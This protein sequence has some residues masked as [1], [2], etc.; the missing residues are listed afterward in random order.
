MPCP[1]LRAGDSA[2][3]VPDPLLCSASYAGADVA[4]LVCAV[5]QGVIV[6]LDASSSLA[7]HVM[8]VPAGT[9]SMPTGICIDGAREQV[10]LLD[11]AQPSL[12]RIALADLRAGNAQFTWTALPSAWSAVRGIAFDS[13]RDRVVG[14]DPTTGDLLQHTAS[15]PSLVAGSLRPLA[16]VFSFGFAPA[17]NPS[18][19]SVDVDLFITSGDERMLT[20][21]WTWNAATTDDELATLRATVLTSTWVPPCPDPAAITYDALND[22]LVVADSEVDEMTIYAGANVFE[23]SRTGVVAR[24]STTVTY[25]PE[26]SGMTLDPVT[27][28]FYFCDDDRDKIYVVA[29]G[30]DGLL[31]T[32]D[33]SIRSFSVRNFCADAESLAFDSATGTLWIAGGIANLLHKLRPGANGIFDGTPPNGDDVLASFDVAGFGVTDLGGVALRPADGGLYV[34]G[35]P[36]TRLLHLN[37]QGQLVRVITLPATSM[38]RPAGLVFAPSTVGAGDSLFLVDR[39]H[40]NDLEPFENDGKLRQ[41]T[42]P[43]PVV[44]NQPPVVS[45]GP[46]VATS[47]NSAAHLAGLVSDDGLPFGLLTVEW[48]PMAGPGTAT[49][50][51][52]TQPV[53]DAS[54]SAA[55]SYTLELSAYDGELVRVDTVVVT[56]TQPNLPPV[57]DAGPDVAT[58]GTSAAH[59]AGNVSDDGLQGPLAI[60]WTQL[61]GPG[62]ASFTAPNQAV[63]D[64]SFSAVGSYTIQLSAF[65]GELTSTD[66][67]VVAVAQPNLAPVVNAGPDVTTVIPSMAHLVGT[68]SDDGLQR[69]LTI[70]W[71][72]LSGP[73][74]ASFTAPAQPVTDVSF[75]LAGSYTLELSAFDGGLTSTDTVVVTAQPA[76]S[77]TFNRAIS[78]GNDDAEERPT[79]IDRGSQTLEMVLDG[80]VSQVV[81]LRFTSVAIPKGAVITSAYLQFTTERVTSVA[82]Q[83]SIVGQASDNAAPFQ[84]ALLNISSRPD[85]TA[86]VAWA[87]APWTV[88]GQAGLDQRT[89][90]LASIVQ[91]ITNRAGWASG[92]AMV[93]VITG[94]GCR[95]ATSYNR[96]HAAAPNL[97][98]TYHM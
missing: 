56:V 91:E 11:S 67:V 38:V 84:T 20:D 57:V 39:G 32:A 28:T 5:P 58:V 8:A 12:L 35:L 9:W 81:G 36:K 97:V 87:P 63:S 47:T 4:Q 13:E 34:L 65:D 82:T 80:T 93:F 29:T 7:L 49:F 25:T 51:A 1:A 90:S 42:L 60:Q 24:T 73:G 16:T 75:S 77:I 59:L 53:T 92:N 6:L 46:D 10:V 50:S 76:A 18:T 61:S 68:V 33:D 41:Y 69:P 86:S 31:H 85:T 74:L 37:D 94:T 54:F 62:T 19:G 43:A 70:Q 71:R 55:G 17:V 64:V 14:L 79:K 26:P 52:P 83:L 72:Q 78:T 44:T 48:H 21:R 96:S 2:L 45:A 88:V 95:T 66:T 40:D 23:T 89:P 22:R 3:Y 98:V 30:P 15:E 27:R